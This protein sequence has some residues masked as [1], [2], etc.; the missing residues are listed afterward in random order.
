LVEPAHLLLTLGI[1]SIRTL[2]AFGMMPIFSSRTVPAAARTALAV[3]VSLPVTWQQLGKPFPT[4]IAAWPLLAFFG[5]EAVIGLLIGL[6]FGIF[7]AGLLIIG[8]IIDHQTGLTFTQNIDPVH[9]NTVSLTSQY[10]ER[11]LFAALMLAGLMH[12]VVDALYLSYE[13]WP[14]GA[15]LPAFDRVYPLSLVTQTSRLFALALLLSGPV[16]LALFVVDAA[17]GLLNRAAPQ[18]SLFH[19]TMSLKSL[20]AVGVLVLALPMMLQR[21]VQALPE[22][23][24]TLKTLLQGLH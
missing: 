8:E 20:V 2:V 23:T 16:V 12:G 21:V 5:K 4:D 3:A 9:G 13:I 18:L 15:W 11:V 1:S 14:I 10:L 6:G 17:M 19:I 7:L 22:V 24:G